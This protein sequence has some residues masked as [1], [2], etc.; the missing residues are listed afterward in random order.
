[1]VKLTAR[2]APEGK[3]TYTK[4]VYIEPS[5]INIICENELGHTWLPDFGIVVLEKPEQIRNIVEEKGRAAQHGEMA[6]K[7]DRLYDKLDEV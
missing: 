7:V 1:M 3:D 4:P 6:S 5:A 2:F